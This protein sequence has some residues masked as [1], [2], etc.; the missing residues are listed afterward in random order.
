MLW[1]F[2]RLNIVFNLL[3]DKKKGIRDGM[4]FESV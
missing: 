4:S 3:N 1:F 2:L